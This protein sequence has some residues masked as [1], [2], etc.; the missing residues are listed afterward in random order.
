[1]LSNVHRGC[2]SHRE[3]M[4]VQNMESHTDNL[5]RYDGSPGLPEHQALFSTAVPGG[6]LQNALHYGKPPDTSSVC[7]EG[8]P[9]LG[10]L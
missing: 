6:Y 8:A 4:T 10:F 1:M 9:L 2:L 7:L 3:D 5:D